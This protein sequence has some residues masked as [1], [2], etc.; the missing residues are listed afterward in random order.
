M[1]IETLKSYY[2]RQL[3]IHYRHSL[4]VT[5]IEQHMTHKSE[6]EWKERGKIIGGRG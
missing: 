5:I 3:S 1:V 4:L 6:K 2:A